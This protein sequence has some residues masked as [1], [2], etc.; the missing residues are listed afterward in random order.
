[1]SLDRD[2]VVEALPAYVVGE[3]IGRGAFGI[4]RAGRHRRLE[5]EVAIKHLGI[6]LGLDPQVRAR[7]VAEARL[8]ASLDHPHIVPIYDYVEHE[9]LCLLVMERLTGGTVWSRFLADGFTPE[10]ACEVLIGTCAGLDHAHRKG[11][12]HRDIKPE[13]LMF[14]GAGVLK[15]AD[16]GIAKVVG[17]STGLA[18]RTGAV[19]GTPAY[20]APEQAEGAAVT[21]ATDVYA[22]GLV[23]Y[24]LLSGTRPFPAASDPIAALYQRVHNEPRALL[25]AAPGVPPPLAGVVQQ[26]IA[27]NPADRYPSA[28]AFGAAITSAAR[29]IWGTDWVPRHQD[30]TSV[31]TSDTA[32]VLARAGPPGRPGRPAPAGTVAE[33]VSSYAAGDGTSAPTVVPGRARSRGRRGRWIAAAVGLVGVAGGGVAL[34]A[35][36]DTGSGR[37]DAPPASPAAQVRPAISSGLTVRGNHLAT[38]AGKHIRLLGVNRDGVETQ[39][40][41]PGS[42]TFDGPTNQASVTAMARWNVNTVRIGLNE[43]CWLGVND[44]PSDGTATAHRAAIERYV[45]LLARNGIYTVIGLDV[46]T[47]G[48]VRSTATEQLQLPD[49]DHAPAFWRS[50]ARRFRGSPSVLFD[51]Y[52]EPHDVTWECWQAGCETAG[53]RLAGMQ[54]LVDAIRGAG[55]RQPILMAGLS[56]GGDLRGWLGYR[57]KDP[58]GRLVA[59]LTTF[60]FSPCDASCQGV[61]SGLAR[62][63]PI[64]ATKLGE[65]DCRHDYIDGFMRFADTAGISYLGWTWNGGGEWTCKGGMALIKDYSGTPT[66]FGLGLRDHLNALRST[67]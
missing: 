30:V 2:L 51:L 32:D 21:P 18:T 64:V 36:G 24:E 9:G 60:E 14:S 47:P 65:T 41:R 55:A 34:I 4:V 22:A 28:A 26:A 10:A 43:A 56:Y 6:S 62:R 49:A 53:V 52:S 16:F 66:A 67:R 15:V 45:D 8:L 40:T 35:G 3:E 50:V 11:V 5:R 54:D 59:A 42:G 33:T 58:L 27:R 63:V 37:R 46:A 12:L 39:C 61:L 48:R 17:G 19:L 7:F 20:I 1:M 25:D 29:E 38:A 31:A 13:N 23:L 57:P 44:L